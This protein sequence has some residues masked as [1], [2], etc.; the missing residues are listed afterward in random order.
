M[1]LKDDERK[2]LREA[3]VVGGG[4]AAI[5]LVIGGV[6]EFPWWMTLP[7][8]VLMLVISCALSA[9][10]LATAR[11]H[12]ERRENSRGTLIAWADRHE[13]RCGTDPAAFAG[14]GERWKLPASPLFR[15]DLLAVGRRDGV[16]VAVACVT[17][18]HDD[19]MAWYM[20]VLVRLPEERPRARL[21]YPEI[22]RLALPQ[23]A[24]SVETDGRELR[25][26]YPGW[27][28]RSLV[29]NTRV[30]AAVRVAAGLPDT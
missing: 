20:V 13:G 6:S 27:P 3:A 19:G 8:V 24:G 1:P 26:R 29:L 10:E 14:E 23:G 5:V 11:R 9:M 25:V 7:L 22:R 17:A 18:E 28:E 30:D 12:A 16:E 21:S 2:A 4:G 15:G